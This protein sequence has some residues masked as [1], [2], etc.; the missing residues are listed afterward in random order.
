[1][2]LFRRSVT[3][4][5]RRTMEKGSRLNREILGVVIFALALLTALSLLSYHPTDRSFN[6]PSGSLQTQNWGGIVG[7]Y[8]ADLLLVLSTFLF[9]DVRTFVIGCSATVLG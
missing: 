3:L 1:M 8:L 9:G 6:T 2:D 4:L 5:I 7:A